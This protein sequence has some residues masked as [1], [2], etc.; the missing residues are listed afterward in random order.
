MNER[1]RGTRRPQI[2]MK[3]TG[4]RT[5]RTWLLLFITFYNY[6]KEECAKATRHLV[7]EAAL[8]IPDNV[9]AYLDVRFVRASGRSEE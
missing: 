9:R 4:A 3:A 1:P 2:D 7:P 6:L 5:M 8:K